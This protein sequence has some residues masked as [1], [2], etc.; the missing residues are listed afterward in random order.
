MTTQAIVK[1]N[2]VN[3]PDLSADGFE[4]TTEG[5]KPIGAPTRDQCF[6]AMQTL[7]QYGGWLNVRVKAWQLAMG[8][9]WNYMYD[10]FREEAFQAVTGLDYETNTYQHFGY[11]SKRIPEPVRREIPLEY[12]Y[13]R[14]VAPC[15][16]LDERRSW[17]KA[18]R[19]NE[20]TV[21]DLRREMQDGHATIKRLPL[22]VNVLFGSWIERANYLNRSQDDEITRAKAETYRQCADE[23]KAALEQDHQMNARKQ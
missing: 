5:L 22:A 14:E 10:R 15:E 12:S 1:S 18:A 21:R 9:M 8:D 7:T 17:L 4:F 13:Y 6:Q 2:G 16:T 19:D 20:W 11:V 3:L 23:L